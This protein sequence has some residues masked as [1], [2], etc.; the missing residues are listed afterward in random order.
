MLE[1]ISYI[2]AFLIS[3]IGVEAFRRW[4]ERNKILDIPNKRSSHE[5]PTPKGG[6]LI[7][8]IVSIGFFLIFQY[9]YSQTILWS[10][11]VG[12]GLIALVSWLDDIYSLPVFGRFL[13]HFFAAGLVVFQLN[14]FGSFYIPILNQINL[15]IAGL[16]FT[17]FW[18][19]WIT[20]AFN[21]MDGIDGIAGL[22]ALTASVGWSLVGWYWGIDIFLY[23]GLIIFSSVL[24]FLIHNWHPA[25]IFMGDVGSAFLGFTFAVFPL[26]A[27]LNNKNEGYLIYLPFISIAFL[28]LF[29]FDSLITL[30]RRLL[31][32]EKIWQAHRQHLYQILVIRDH[33]HDFVAALYGFLS[34]IVVFAV[35]YFWVVNKSD[36]ILISL[37]L[38][39]TIILVLILYGRKLLTKGT[40]NVTF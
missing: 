20:N 36:M 34:I 26:F 39:V 3:L 22:Q 40:Q 7:I 15:G 6:G 30:F 13:C 29:V 38:I 27:N 16:F 1:I 8:V 14:Y 24:G 21:F 2:S 32:G 10:Y 28:W 11:F 5:I 25:K 35:Y 9:Y 17:V 37:I 31:R 33:S 4:S 12:A 19:V 18:I 23:F